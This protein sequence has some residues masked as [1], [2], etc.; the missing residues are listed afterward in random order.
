MLFRDI[1]SKKV[2]SAKHRTEWNL[3]GDS[4]IKPNRTCLVA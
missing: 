4:D 1:V 3:A 2:R